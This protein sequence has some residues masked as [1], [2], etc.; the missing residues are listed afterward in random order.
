MFQAVV[1]R[2]LV[3]GFTL[4]ELLVVITIIGVLVSLL[5]P[6]VQSARGG[7]PN[8]V[9]EQSETTCPRHRPARHRHGPLSQQRLGPHLHRRCRL[10]N[11]RQSAGRLD[12]QRSSL[13][14]AAE[15]T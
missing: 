11:R 5:L 7:P 8:A 15:F 12:L 14:R 2:G 13:H 9:P 3:R 6:A 1:R 4:V 10:R